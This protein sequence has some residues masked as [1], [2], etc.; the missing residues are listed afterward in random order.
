MWICE[1]C[2]QQYE[3]PK[4]GS[5]HIRWHHRKIKFSPSAIIKRAESNRKTAD[6][7]FGKK[8]RIEK[9][10]T[11]CHK[12]FHYTK[13]ENSR[14]LKQDKTTCSRACAAKLSSSYVNKNNISVAMKN[15][16]RNNPNHPWLQSWKSE[17]RYTSKNEIL[18]RNHFIGKDDWTFGT[19]ANYKFNQ[20]NPD[21][22]SKNY[23]IVFEYDGIWHFKD[24][25]S[26]L[27]KKQLKDKLLEKW[28]L[29]NGY[30]LIRISEE[31]F[32]EKEFSYWIDFLENEFFNGTN[33]ILKIY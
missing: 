33:Q 21:L 31:R 26:Q 27:R 11:V 17:K 9:N 2:G 14:N 29:K 15:Y 22:W 7:L 25:H 13:N 12:N 4:S 18:I 1:E 16:I 24:I 10:C 3:N 19:I 30:R 5:N 32:K 6:R 8:I 23:K 28:C 20:L